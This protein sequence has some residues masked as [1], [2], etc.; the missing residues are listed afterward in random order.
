MMLLTHAQSPA[1]ARDFLAMTSTLNA[2]PISSLTFR[3]FSMF[4]R[5]TLPASTA[6]LNARRF[7][8]KPGLPSISWALFQ[9]ATR[10][11]PSAVS[12]T[13]GSMPA[14]RC[15]K[16]MQTMSTPL[17]GFEKLFSSVI[18][19]LLKEL[20]AAAASARRHSA[21]FCANSVLAASA[22]A[23]PPMWYLTSTRAKLH[24]DAHAIEALETASGVKS[25]RDMY[26]KAV[27]RASMGKLTWSANK[28]SKN[29]C[30]SANNCLDDSQ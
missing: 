17:G 24:S 16:Q 12:L 6:S 26:G 30:G 15:N 3:A 25:S 20:S 11:L 18:S 29:N 23:C 13:F 27:R 21:G 5:G 28:R 8:R 1:A 19:A 7:F 2:F 22:T 10:T 9:E 4:F 14:K